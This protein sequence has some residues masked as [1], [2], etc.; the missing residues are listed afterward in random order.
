MGVSVY[1]DARWATSQQPAERGAT[2]SEGKL[3]KR[4]IWVECALRTMLVAGVDTDEGWDE[5]MQLALEEKP[6]ADEDL[7]D[8]SQLAAVASATL[9]DAHRYFTGSSNAA[10]ARA[11]AAS[12]AATKGDVWRR[13]YGMAE[14]R[15]EGVFFEG[16]KANERMA[17]CEKD[18]HGAGF[19]GSARTPGDKMMR[20]EPWQDKGTCAG[21]LY[22]ARMGIEHKHVTAALGV[23]AEV[24]STQKWAEAALAACGF[25]EA[26]GE[27]VEVILNVV[28]PE[29]QTGEHVS[30][31]N[32]AGRGGYE[33]RCKRMGWATDIGPGDDFV[34]AVNGRLERIVAEAAH[35]G[36][37]RGS[38]ERSPPKKGP[39]TSRACCPTCPSGPSQTQSKALYP[40]TRPRACMP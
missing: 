19:R 28:S 1:D 15:K 34:T 8:S 39:R 35:Q 29:L 13:W 23:I 36:A 25:G 33:E 26:M 21:D 37:G 38:E 27:A 16:T 6:N 3:A 20:T 32:G 17:R 11:A 18:G 30:E 5:A 9:P 4:V 24:R 22:A 31:A 10:P 12:A 7:S 40:A 2:C 14:A